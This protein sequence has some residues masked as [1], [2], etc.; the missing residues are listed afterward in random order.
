MN[1]RTCQHIF[2]ITPSFWVLYGGNK[3]FAISFVDCRAEQQEQQKAAQI[4]S[5][6]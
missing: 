2:T 5:A 1:T 3:M 6:F 4:L